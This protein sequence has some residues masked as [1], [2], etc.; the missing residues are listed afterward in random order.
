MLIQPLFSFVAILNYPFARSP[1]PCRGRVSEAFL[2][3][4]NRWTSRPDR[5]LELVVEFP[6]PTFLLWGAN[7]MHEP[8]M[9]IL[10]THNTSFHMKAEG[11]T[12]TLKLKIASCYTHACV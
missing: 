7:L 2:S 11:T 4:S 5:A 9:L 8:K 3:G 10:V 1:G 6:P 12:H